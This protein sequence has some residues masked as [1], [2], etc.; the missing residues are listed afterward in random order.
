MLTLNKHVVVVGS[1]LAGITASI[2]LLYSGISITI[3]EK[4]DRLGGNSMKASSGINATVTNQQIEKGILGDSVQSFLE[5][6]INSGKGL[7]DVGLLELLTKNSKLSIEWL[8]SSEIG[9]DLLEVSLLGGHSFPR[10]HKGKSKP[11]GFAIMSALINILDKFKADTSSATLR[12]LK[13][14]KLS[15]I[16][17]SEGKKKIVGVEYE[18]S[19]TLKNK[20][21][22]DHL[23]L[24]TG[25]Y[26]ADFSSQNSLLKKYRQDL[27]NLPLTNSFFTTGDGQKIASRDV[28]AELIQMD[29]I[30]VHPTGFIK[31][32]KS[33]EDVNSKWKFLCGE[34]IRGIGG[35][36]VT[37]SG[38]RFVNEL[39]TRDVVSTAIFDNCKIS[40][41]NQ[42]S[43]A[44][45]VATAV[46]LLNELDYNKA[47]SHV[48]FYVSQGL[49]KKGTV[50]EVSET[51]VGLSGLNKVEVKKYLDSTIEEYNKAIEG[52]EE[53]FGRTDFGEMFPIKGSNLYY[54]LVTPVLHFSMGGLKINE[55]GRVLNTEH[56]I[57]EGLYAAGEA[58]GGVHGGNRLG[59]NSLLECV[60]FGTIVADSIV[61]DFMD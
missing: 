28:N 3:L 35:I 26:S 12:V 56:T 16:L 41:H 25:G 50:N 21:P 39:S 38:K 44:P 17:S 32:F 33:S 9:V 54:G 15:G 30:Q 14:C 57:I 31:T 22:C 2:K 52:N 43:L 58:S 49:L 61:R 37:P 48:D 4:A 42:L 40:P 24:A 36:L 34:V 29:Q 23:I 60:V 55:E 27:V 11:P 20:L 6:S 19:E 10:T 1:G 51:L 5:D 53:R 59:G 46:L 8:T 47:S 13:N 7:S 18:E 45:D